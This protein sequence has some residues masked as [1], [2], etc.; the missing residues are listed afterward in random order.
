MIKPVL[1]R[2]VVHDKEDLFEIKAG[3][4]PYDI[5]PK[6]DDEINRKIIVRSGCEIKGEI[7]GGEIIL[8]DKVK[9]LSVCGTQKV[10]IKEYC[11]IA[12]NLQSKGD[13][14]LGKHN[15]IIG[16]IIGNQITINDNNNIRGNVI[17]KGNINI[18]NNTN[19]N[20]LLISIE[21]S[22]ALGNNSEVFDV[23][24]MNNMLLGEGVTIQDPVIWTKKGNISFSNI[25][26]ARDRP[27]DKNDKMIF[28]S[29]IVNPYNNASSSFDVLKIYQSFKNMLDEIS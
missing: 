5:L 17:S 15:K 28:K 9:T 1:S 27:I 7:L 20:G 24:C 3:D 4:Y 2:E 19:I 23:I 6:T 26:I 21:G 8:F 11:Q 12:G 13:I 22:I 25:Q 10:T 16:D 14:I 18:G 29:N